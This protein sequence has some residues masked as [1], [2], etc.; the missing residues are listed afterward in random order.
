MGW[1]GGVCTS[2]GR[3]SV[4]L[5]M[6]SQTAEVQIQEALPAIKAIA[7][8]YGQRCVVLSILEGYTKEFA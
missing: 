4:I 2:W 6:M 5:K 3:I 8:H 1:G 7:N